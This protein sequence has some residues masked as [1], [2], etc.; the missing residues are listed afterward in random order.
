M[1]V[2]ESFFLREGFCVSKGRFDM[3]HFFFSISN[4]FEWETHFRKVHCLLVSSRLYIGL[5]LGI[6]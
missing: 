1:Y 3:A 2:G 4:V 5:P 6:L